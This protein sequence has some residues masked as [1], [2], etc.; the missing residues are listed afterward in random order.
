MALS[1]GGNGQ[2]TTFSGNL[3]GPGSLT[4]TGPGTL[5]LTGMNTFAGSTTVSSGTLQLA[6]G[7]LAPPNA[8]EFVGSGGTGSFV[9][10]GGTNAI[11]TS[12]NSLYLGYNSGDIG[13]YV[14][15]GSGFL[16]ANTEYVGF[17][18]SGT[19]TQSGGT[20]SLSG[21]LTLAQSA[22]SSGTYNLNGGLLTLAGLTQGG[23]AATSTSAAARSRPAPA[24]PAACPS[25][26]P[27]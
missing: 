2:S 5:T 24:F 6:A 26:S 23:G 22:G 10:T 3:T 1:V 27:D 4:K 25:S 16:T 14:L 7:S 12:S 20:N 13:S 21:S 17:Q 19:F 9:Q 15:N 11:N 8:D 18:G